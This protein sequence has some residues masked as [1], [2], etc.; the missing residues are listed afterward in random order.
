MLRIIHCRMEESD[1]ENERKKNLK[2]IVWTVNACDDFGSNSVSEECVLCAVCVRIRVRLCDSSEQTTRR[3]TT[4]TRTCVTRQVPVPIIA[5][6][7]YKLLLYPKN[8]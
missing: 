8:R 6:V 4:V 2:R 7:A 1:D 5:S 3:P